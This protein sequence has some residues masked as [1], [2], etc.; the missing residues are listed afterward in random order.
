[1]RRLIAVRRQHRSFGRGTMTFIYPR[2]RKIL[3]YVREFMG[4]RILCV[5]NVSHTPQAVE[6]EL[7]EFAGRVPIELSGSSLFPPIGQLTYLLTL[8]GH[9]FYWFALREPEPGVAT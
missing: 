1:M 2:N 7:S 6:L 8:P 4:E 3:C 5:A 9:G